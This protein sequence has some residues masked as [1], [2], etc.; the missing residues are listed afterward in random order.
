[1]LTY[2]VRPGGPSATVNGDSV[3]VSRLTTYSTQLPPDIKEDVPVRE[4]GDPEQAFANQDDEI[5]PIAA[6]K[7]K[8]KFQVID[9]QTGDTI[10]TF[11][12]QPKWGMN[13][14]SWNLRRDGVEMPS[15]RERKEDADPPTGMAVVPGTYRIIMTYGTHTDET[16]VTVQA[17]PRESYSGSARYAQRDD[18][19]QQL[20]DE[21]TGVTTAFNRLQEA[22]K[23]ITR[24]EGVMAN[25]PKAVKDTLTKETKAL[26][27]EIARLEEIVTEPEDLKGI[28]R[29]PT[30]LQSYLYGA[31]NYISQIEG[32]P[33]QMAELMLQQFGD[34]ADDFIQQ[35]NTF[36]SGDLQE[37]RDEVKA[38]NLSL[39][40]DLD[41]VEKD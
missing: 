6:P 22:R 20:E 40:G 32:E 12:Q 30:N 19:N 36:L 25:A 15:R 11:T 41:P 33:N 26:L 10:R 5:E 8:I 9:V 28:Q 1:M 13:R 17:D 24:V 21:V 2:W 4:T 16:V 23:S 29:N 18:L 14:T 27:K 39:F 38:A 34:K 35:V 37:F 7:E 31:R 3:D